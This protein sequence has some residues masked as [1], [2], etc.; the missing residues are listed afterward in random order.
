MVVAYGLDKAEARLAV[1]VLRTVFSGFPNNTL[2]EISLIT[3]FADLT[4]AINV[5]IALG[6]LVKRALWDG[7]DI[8]LLGAEEAG[9][10]AVA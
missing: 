8:A 3:F 1:A 10:F 4:L 2:L 6:A 7:V 9:S 5:S